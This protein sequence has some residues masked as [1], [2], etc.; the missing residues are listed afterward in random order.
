MGWPK[1]RSWFVSDRKK[2]SIED[3]FVRLE[4]VVFSLLDYLKVDAVMDDPFDEYTFVEIV[5]RG[6][7]N[8]D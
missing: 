4:R 8:D 1:F 2:V 5:K 6:K 3:R 7:K